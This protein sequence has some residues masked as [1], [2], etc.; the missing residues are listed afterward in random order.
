MESKK[1][2]QSIKQESRI[3]LLESFR[4]SNAS[5]LDADGR[6]VG[7]LVQ[8]MPAEVVDIILAYFEPEDI[9]KLRNI[10]KTWNNYLTQPG[11]LN[12]FNLKI[13]SGS[14]QHLLDSESIQSESRTF[15]DRVRNLCALSHGRACK[16]E[17]IRH[18][19]DSR[20]DIIYCSG[21]IVS[22]W[23]ESFNIYVQ[24]LYK[25]DA[26]WHKLESDYRENFRSVKLTSKY[27]LAY[28][29]CG[30]VYCWDISTL[31]LLVTFWATAVPE[32]I[33][34]PTK[35]WRLDDLHTSQMRMMDKPSHIDASSNTIVV[36]IS[37][38]KGY[39]YSLDTKSLTVVH[40]AL[41]RH[42]FDYNFEKTRVDQSG[43]IYLPINDMHCEQYVDV[44]KI[45]DTSTSIDFVNCIDLQ[46]IG[47]QQIASLAGD[48]DGG[49]VAGPNDIYNVVV[50]WNHEYLCHVHIGPIMG[51]RIHL[52][53][54]LKDGL[55]KYHHL[56]REEQ[57]F[58]LS[59]SIYY[60]KIRRTFHFNDENRRMPY[61]L[62]QAHDE[63]FR[64]VIA[65]KSKIRSLGKILKSRPAKLTLEE[66][67]VLRWLEHHHCNGGAYESAIAG[68]SNF[69]VVTPGG[70]EFTMVWKFYGPDESR[71]AAER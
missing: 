7:D 16:F 70:A 53:S 9:F 1:V 59:R 71:L 21:T 58:D 25:N 13:F 31:H 22:W 34:G 55:M 44:F 45:N 39:L 32:L 38:R 42:S 33:N 62:Y 18:S 28:T 51:T 60:P 46:A 66:A 14:G 5:P 30:Q 11:F 8:L 69:V 65:G 67:E 6:F 63:T 17:H 27:I 3:A 48:R 50:I 36:L 40:P 2:V 37:L 20:D 54:E 52:I 68:D 56:I 47:K 64:P 35:R 10:S 49:L 41:H 15:E 43:Y 29:Q 57:Y 23:E 19:N 12:H 24:W 4:P 26:E 61:C